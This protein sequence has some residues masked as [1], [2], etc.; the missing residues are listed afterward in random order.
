MIHLS[1]R[2][3]FIS[4]FLL[5][6]LALGACSDDQN[7][8]GG[9]TYSDVTPADTR[10]A[11]AGEDARTN[12]DPSDVREERDTRQPRD[13]DPGWDWDLG[14]DVEEEPFAL[15][16]VLPASGPMQGGNRVRVVGT[17][18]E[19][20]TRVFFGEHEMTV[21]VTRTQMLGRV[22]ASN[23]P[24]VVTVKAIGPDGEVR[25]LPDAYEYVEGLTVERVTPRRIPTRGGVEVEVRGSGFSPDMAVNF[26]GTPAR[27]ITYID[28]GLLRV[29]TPPRPAGQADLQLTTRSESARAANAIEYYEEL[30]ITEVRPAS[31]P[32]GGGQTVTLKGSGFESGM[33]FLFGGESAQVL[34]VDARNGSATVRTP[35]HAAGL[36]SVSAQTS[37][38][39]AISTN[40]YLY[41]ANATA[42]IAA[43]RPSVGPTSG[44]TDVEIIGVGLNGAG[45]AFDFGANQATVI[46]RDDS[47]ARVRTP[48]APAGR[49]DVTMRNAGGEI[50]RLTDAF[51]YQ[52]ALEIASLSP[53]EGPVAGGTSV[54]ILGSGF[55][56]AERVE[57]GGIAAPFTV[58]SDTQ[59]TAQSPA[60]GAG[61]VD[62]RVSRG[63]V[64]SVAED[65]FNYTQALEIWGFT[66]IRGAIAG[67]TYVEVRGQGFYGELRAYF[68][69]IEATDVQRVDRNNLRLYT[70]P[71]DAGEAELRIEARSTAPGDSQ[72][73]I[74][75]A[76]GPYPFEFYNPA[77]R[78]GGASGEEVAG[79]VNVSVYA[80]GGTPIP[81]AFVMLSTRG[82]TQYQGFT[83]ANGQLTLSGPHVLGPQTV[84]ATAR[85]FSSATIH[86]IDA[87]NITLF[88]TYLVLDPDGEGGGGTPGPPI[89]SA[90]IRGEVLIQGKLANPDDQHTY[91]MAVVGTTR[92]ARGG[93]R[94]N[95][96]PGATVMGSGRY[97]IVS[98]TGDLA[99]VALCG[100]YNETTDVFTPQ[101]MGIERYMVVND[102][103]T[104][105]V[106]LVCDIPLD[107]VARVKLVNPVYSPQ[108][109]DTN[110]VQIHW[111]FGID[112]VFT[113]P[114]MGRGF[115]DIVEVPAQPE[116][117]GVLQDLRYSLVGGS[118]TG[119]YSPSTQSMLDGVSTLEHIIVMPPLLDVPEPV[120]PVVGGNI[121]N[122][123]VVFQVDGPHYADFYSV[124]FVNDDGLPFWELVIPGDQHTIRLPDFP[125]FSF[126]PEEQ[127]PNPWNTSRIYMTM[128]GVRS[129]PDFVFEE[130][131]YR[132]LRSERWRAYSLTRWSFLPPLP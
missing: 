31:G 13:T 48:A 87:E 63:G 123:T 122:N 108:G 99:T 64:A 98:R 119:Q 37:N 3:A 70:P 2:R 117:T 17:G 19:P 125:D 94:L 62:V 97:D 82:D 22:P 30:A 75:S 73:T 116:A 113:A 29:L 103:E 43:I 61:L 112:G 101:F 26:S 93:G 55:T 44:G 15:E 8:D 91:D 86:A 89:P 46:A 68:D 38:D 107:Q 127:R 23:S 88:L 33:R 16:R 12:N 111:D 90:R 14:G 52:Q 49:V 24:R 32:V 74:R 96:G 76:T 36:V 67:N 21:E 58:D 115:A 109:P 56:G 53:S 34:S 47:W 126:L 121:V 129:A 124:Q 110:L 131:T 1:K 100:V 84:T 72:E 10:G 83:D 66:P 35:A 77:N 106:D 4:L 45:V 60:H 41:T 114:I 28:S 6:L 118:F 130:F 65:A 11:D 69:D 20:G 71:H 42:Q 25:A 50:G 79:S 57:F 40:A 9:D 102:Q 95:P 80:D 128:I 59:I 132:D 78:F 120:S 105:E 18:F 54:T 92:S 39:N 85:D 27:R 7:T 5:C 81:N 51:E 104:Y